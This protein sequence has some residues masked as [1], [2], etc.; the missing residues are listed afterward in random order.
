MHTQQYE[1]EAEE[2]EKMRQELEQ[3]IQ[4]IDAGE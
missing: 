2:A 3:E 1:K 4:V